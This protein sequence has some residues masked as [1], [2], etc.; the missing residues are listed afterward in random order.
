MISRKNNSSAFTLNLLLASIFLFI[1]SILFTLYILTEKRIDAANEL[2]YQSYLLANELRQSSDDLTRAVRTY[3]ASG[4]PVYKQHYSEIIDIRNGKR[5]RKPDYH[6]A[7]WDFNTQ[8]DHHSNLGSGNSVPLMELIGKAGFSENELAKLNEAKNKSDKL[9]ELEFSAMAL[10]ETSK[11]AGDKPHMEALRVLHGDTYNQAKAA[12]M[13]SISD[14]YRMM[15]ERTSN[16]VNHQKQLALY[17]RYALIFVGFL[18]LFFLWRTYR[19]MRSTLGAPLNEVQAQIARIGSG[20]FKDPIPVSRGMENSVMSWLSET[21]QRLSKARIDNDRLTRLYATLSYCNEA[22]VRS[23]NSA[24]LFNT[25]CRY[26]VTHG[27]MSMCWIGMHDETTHLVT[28][29]AS[30]G[31]GTEYLDGIVISALADH[32]YGQGPTGISMREDR[33]VWCNDFTRNPMTAAWHERGRNFGWNASASLPLHEKDSVIGVINFYS[34][35]VNVFEDDVQTLLSEMTLDISAAIGRFADEQQ[36]NKMQD[37]LRKLSLAVEQSPNAIVITDL[38]AKIVFANSALLKSSGYSESEMIGQNPRILQSGK[39]PKQTY[40]DMWATITRGEIWKGEFIN[41]RKDGTEYIEYVMISPIRDEAGKITN[42]LAI[43]DDITEKLETGERIQFLA[44]FDQLTGLPNRTLLHDHFRYALSLAQHSSNNLAI[45]LV[46]LDHFKYINDTLGHSIGDQMLIELAKRIKSVLRDEDTVSR[47]GGD[48]FVIVLPTASANNAANLADRLLEIISVPF[49]VE[50]HELITT[51]SIGIA[52]YPNDGNDI[53]MLYKNADNAMYKAKQ[54]GRNGF[55]F[56]TQE[57]QANTERNLQLANA[58]RFAI[59]R[60]QLYLHYQPQVSVDD[61]RI[62]GAETLIRWQHP[63]LGMLP[64]AEF[65]PIAEN[66]GQIA[67]IGEWVLRSA[68]RQMKTWLD[69][70]L[71]IPVIAVN[72]STIQFRDSNF[73]ELVTSIL[74][75]ENLP[76]RYLELEL[77]EAAAMDNPE[78][79]VRMMDKLDNLGIRM[80]IDDFG[81]GYSSLSYLKRFK[82]YKLK[83]DRTFVRDITEDAEDKAIVAAIINMAT[84][85]GIRT[86]AEGVET[87]GQLG[88]LRLQGCNE[89]QG[90]YF[91]RPV[92][93]DQF[94]AYVREA[95]ATRSA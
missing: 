62:I 70:G 59:E 25:I 26:A 88:F 18:L 76:H 38:D 20:D 75:D 29:V 54:S 9:T 16:S 45:M 94:E 39:T 36:K 32:Q 73:P 15:E 50:Q 31:Q 72:I 51:A 69:A 30:F 63:E 91:S 7:Y 8:N 37:D 17:T 53:E 93:A 41:R 1:Y 13:K 19:S 71:P 6:I 28:P 67:K 90:Y 60:D 92:P 35:E 27:G 65:I 74:D 77:T 5:P 48:E 23:K 86:I 34:T 52:I 84:S 24:E 3:V 55:R 80:S 12:I 21:Q 78:A 42:Y 85:L 47:S 61:G 11:H 87:A 81:T 83:I 89:V 57:M 22:I 44:H 33:A 56:F 68:A 49:T 40:E 43:K 64:P 2:R 14:C 4:D 95:V 10:F 82:V 46:D 79:A 58:L 66:T